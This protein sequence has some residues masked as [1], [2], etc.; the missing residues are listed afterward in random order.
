MLNV[1]RLSCPVDHL[2]EDI[3]GSGAQGKGEAGPSAW[4]L[5]ESHP[6]MQI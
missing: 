2:D 6:S 3:L 1:L 4:E 5:G